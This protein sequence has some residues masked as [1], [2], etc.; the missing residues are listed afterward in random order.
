MDVFSEACGW[1][2][3]LVSWKL[4]ERDWQP[5]FSAVGG[6]PQHID[7]ARNGF[8]LFLQGRRLKETSVLLICLFVWS[9]MSSLAASLFGWNSLL[10]LILC[11][12]NNQ[13]KVTMQM[14]DVSK[15]CPKSVILIM[16][17]AARRRKNQAAPVKTTRKGHTDENARWVVNSSSLKLTLCFF[18]D[19]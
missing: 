5:L 17:Q 16:Q 8:T 18:C 14:M 11:K 10:A 13:R 19:Y 9:P 12:D 3:S 6:Q 15:N 4:F 2:G 7:R 1:F